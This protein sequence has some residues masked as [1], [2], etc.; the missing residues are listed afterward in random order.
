MVQAGAGE[1]QRSWSPSQGA[2][3][4]RLHTRPI[5]CGGAVGR[6]GCIRARATVPRR[7][8]VVPARHTGPSIR[9]VSAA[10][11]ESSAAFEYAKLCALAVVALCPSSAQ[12]HEMQSICVACRSKQPSQ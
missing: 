8:S 12:E 5:G 3:L 6:R 9:P 2:A 10:E 4:W 7:R 11:L 1:C